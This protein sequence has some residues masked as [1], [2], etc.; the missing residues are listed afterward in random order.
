MLEVHLLEAPMLRP[1]LPLLLVAAAVP[2][3][4]AP[5]QLQLAPVNDPHSFGNP[6][7]IRVEHIG[8]DLTVDFAKK[9]LHGTALLTVKHEQ[10][11]ATKLVLDTHGLVIEK[12]KAGNGNLLNDA[13]FKLGAED[14]ILGAPLEI[15]LP[16]D[17][18]TVQIAYRTQPGAGGLQ[19]LEPSMT[20]G[21]RQPY[22]FS[23][24]ESIY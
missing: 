19:W 7:E 12:I 17:A 2:G 15:E 1:A 4:C 11:D 10:P 3:L 18:T 13:S 8:L 24:S 23:Q 5:A 22:L 14:K 16:E 21:K 6:Q 9:E 20:A